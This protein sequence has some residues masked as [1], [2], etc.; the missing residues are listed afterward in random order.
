M[1]WQAGTPEVLAALAVQR[2]QHL[3]TES[4]LQRRRTLLAPPEARERT[5][6]V[7]EEI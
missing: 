4:D 5:Y 2:G 6:E 3:P 7:M 1:K